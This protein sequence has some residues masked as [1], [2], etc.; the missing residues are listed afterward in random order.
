MTVNSSNPESVI[1]VDDDNN[2]RLL[3]QR[4]LEIEGYR[5][6]SFG[7]GE[8]CLAELPGLLPVCV[9]LD[10]T[11]PTSHG[12]EILP[13][14]K[15]YQKYLPVIILTADSSAEQVVKAM[16]CGAYDYLVKPIE[17]GK[18]MT[19]VKNAVERFQMAIRL[20]QLE[21]ETS[22][23]TYGFLGNSVQ[24]HKLFRLIDKVSASDIS[25]LIHGESGTGKELAAKAIHQNSGRNTGNFVALNC[26]AI[27]ESLQESE[28]F[29]HEKGSFTGADKRREGRFEMANK[30]TLF[31]D[32]IAELSLPV[33][34]KLL[35]VLQE[36]TFSRLGNS[37]EIKSDFRVI[38]ASHKDLSK[39][40]EAGKFRED[41]F[42][43]IAVYEMDIPPLRERKDDI[44]ILANHFL[45]EF[46]R[47]NGRKL[48][49]SHETMIIL[50]NYSFPGNVREL[51][52]YMQRATISASGEMVLPEDLPKRVFQEKTSET[53]STGEILVSPQHQTKEIADYSAPANEFNGILPKLT[54]EELEK[55][56]IENSLSR[57][58]R[59]LSKVVAELGIGRT[60]LY[61]KLKQYEINV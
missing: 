41:L 52:N 61:R 31:L 27:P 25:V 60:T 5:V 59:N 3:V 26:A 57:N 35:R 11:L 39:E 44:S 2:F 56:A 33:Q 22:G 49:I 8:S 15:A 42:F 14:L 37:N 51:Q 46:S 13:K 28:L 21:R 36:K 17:R 18:L 45:R 34:A 43:R 23:N 19:A 1:V 55:L 40:V 53:F 24:M 32:E 47:K 50:Q 12:L 29:G 20:A 38:A 54:L 9:C 58:N 16:Q 4:W 7:D 30:G 10:L 48:A 6:K